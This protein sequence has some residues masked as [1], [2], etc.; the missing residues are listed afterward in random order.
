ML[1]RQIKPERK[2]MTQAKF[3]AGNR[4][5]L[6]N[7]LLNSLSLSFPLPPSISRL[8]CAEC[9]QGYIFLLLHL[10]VIQSVPLIHMPRSTSKKHSLMP[11]SKHFA[12]LTLIP[13]KCHHETK[14]LEPC[15]YRPL[16]RACDWTT[17]LR[18]KLFFSQKRIS[19][20]SP[21]YTLQLD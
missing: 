3:C 18:A 1:V 19:T 14:D 9:A 2:L 15:L 5:P 13:C 11:L 4:F 10:K 17:V 12:M 6:R 16:P 7:F 20:P 8:L 21:K